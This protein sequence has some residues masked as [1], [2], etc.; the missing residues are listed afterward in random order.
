MQTFLLSFVVLVLC[1]TGM[2]IGVLFGRSP[3]RGSCGGIGGGESCTVCTR[4]CAGERRRR[5]RAARDLPSE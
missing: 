2:A 4:P 3:I 5:A 1:V